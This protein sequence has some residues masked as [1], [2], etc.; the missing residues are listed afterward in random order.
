MSENIKTVWRF[1]Y[2]KL[3]NEQG[4]LDNKKYEYVDGDDWTRIIWRFYWRTS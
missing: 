2:F 4:Q 1:G 3:F